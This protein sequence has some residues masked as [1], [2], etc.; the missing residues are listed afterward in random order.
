MNDPRSNKSKTIWRI[1]IIR[2]CL[3]QTPATINNITNTNNS[4]NTNIKNNNQ[5]TTNNNNNNN[6]KNN[7]NTDDNVVVNHNNTQNSKYPTNS[8]SETVSTNNA[9]HNVNN[10]TILSP[11]TNLDTTDYSTYSRDSVDTSVADTSMTTT[12]TTEKPSQFK[13]LTMWSGLKL[14]VVDIK[15]THKRR[16]LKKYRNS[17]S[18]K[19]ITSHV[20]K[21]L[22]GLDEDK[23]RN[24]T[25]LQASQISEMLMKQD[26]IHAAHGSPALKDSSNHLYHINKNAL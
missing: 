9:N 12:T 10:T 25:R 8:S 17:V 2:Q 20:H 26:L 1:S 22:K 3:S 21:Y 14:H 24:A 23:Y 5:N 4:S 18:G 15:V 6:H 19:E 13:A 16:R 11:Q 7:T